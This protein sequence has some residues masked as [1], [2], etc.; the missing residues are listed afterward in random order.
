LDGHG[1]TYLV[2]W[3]Q[4]AFRILSWLGRFLPNDIKLSSAATISSLIIC[5]VLYFQ[6]INYISKKYFPDGRWDGRGEL[7]PAQGR[8][9]PKNRRKPKKETMQFGWQP[10]KAKISKKENDKETI[11]TKLDDLKASRKY[12]IECLESRQ[13]NLDFL[14]KNKLA[15]KEKILIG[16]ESNKSLFDLLV[17][18]NQENNREVEKIEAELKKAKAEQK[19]TLIQKSKAHDAMYILTKE[20]EELED[21]LET[22]KT[23]AD[24][25][26]AQI[27]EK[28]KQLDEQISKA[29]EESS[30]TMTATTDNVPTSANENSINQELVNF[31]SKK[32]EEKRSL[33]ECPICFKSAK[34]KIFMCTESHLTCSDC[35]LVTASSALRSAPCR[36]RLKD[37]PECRESF[38]GRPLRHRFAEKMAE[39][40]ADLVQ[41]RRKLLKN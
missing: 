15:E 18:K 19:E 27:E 26:I 23:S 41:Q 20:K 28:I 13:K 10:K 38:T 30:T 40:L 17:S 34:K 9:E 4:T 5:L 3:I 7:P 39:E 12:G 32:I 35:R 37:C 33:L 2:S 21:F 36:P 29:L 24:I 25:E 8:K 16:I 6:S 22:E 31:I 11:S 1:H 14:Q